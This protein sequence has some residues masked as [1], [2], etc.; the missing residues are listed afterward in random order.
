MDSSK[1]VIRWYEIAAPVS[2]LLCVLFWYWPIF[3]GYHPVGGDVSAFFYPLMQAYDESLEKGSLVSL[4]NDRWG[5]GFPSLA[6]SQTASLYPIHVLLY[7]MLNTSEAFVVNLLIHMIM[8]ALSAYFAARVMGLRP[9]GA[10]L[11]GFVFFAG[12]FFTVHAPHQWAYMSGS[13]FPVVL[14]ITWKI[15]QLGASGDRDL[16]GQEKQR[17]FS[18]YG[19]LK[20]KQLFRGH[21]QTVLFT[22]LLSGSL[23]CQML[24]GHFQL[25]FITQVMMFLIT[26]F[27]VFQRTTYRGMQCI[28]AGYI[29][30]GWI[31]GYLLAAVQLIPTAELF[32]ESSHDVSRY[33]YLSGFSN[34]PWHLINYGAG[35]LFQNPLWRGLVWS[36]VNPAT[37]DPWHTAPEECLNYVGLIPLCFALGAAWKWR[38][39]PQIR[40][41]ALLALFSLILSLGPY[42]PGFRLLIQLPGFGWFRANARWTLATT[43]WL[44]VLSGFAL[45]HLT[46]DQ[47]RRWTRTFSIAWISVMLTAGLTFWML[48]TTDMDKSSWKE[49]WTNSVWQVYSPWQ[50]DSWKSILLHWKSPPSRDEW[51][52]SQLAT[53]GYDLAKHVPDTVSDQFAWIILR[54]LTPAIGVMILIVGLRLFLRLHPMRWKT[55][56]IVITVLDLALFTSRKPLDWDVPMVPYQSTA[57]Q[58][59]QKME[60]TTPEAADQLIRTVDEFSNLPM[61][62]GLVPVLAYRTLDIPVFPERLAQLSLVGSVPVSTEIRNLLGLSGIQ[63]SI[64]RERG[65]PIS[66]GTRVKDP[67][68]T[69][70]MRGSSYVDQLE[71]VQSE[72]LYYRVMQWPKSPGQAWTIPLSKESKLAK[73][74]DELPDLDSVVSAILT[75]ESP[76]RIICE[77]RVERASL[78][79]VSDLYYPG[80]EVVV[81]NG[82]KQGNQE[83]YRAF[84][85]WR[86]VLLPAAGDYRVTMDYRPLSFQWG[87]WISLVVASIWI[88]AVLSILGGCCY[89]LS[90]RK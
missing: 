11:C 81:D 63:Y 10:W 47:L 38:R 15:L 28:R 89:K 78:L 76:E 69:R 42:F 77:T 45:D 60:E 74:L 40:L 46:G 62:A 9:L 85:A 16:D 79:I 29:L 20:S 84:N 22:L 72:L 57:F 12:D 30:L 6:E 2:L 19:Y 51:T 58:A 88:L 86:A 70:W 35:L 1:Q 34:T 33:E 49:R 5:Y 17:S 32:Q 54:E 56:A 13:W 55:L 87:K 59:I 71:R 82:V 25:A 65:Y 8:A 50:Q 41:W 66:A 53:L 37:S 52:M 75:R 18:E 44:S 43:F 39:T 61:A 73:T 83:M 24:T 80:W 7:S 14:M 21:S 3:F 23:A 90:E 68:L 36:P 67:Q 26:G 31:A 4:W 64:L 27:S 48:V